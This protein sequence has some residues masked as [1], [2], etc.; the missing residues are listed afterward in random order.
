MTKQRPEQH[1]GPPSVAKSNSDYQ[2]T[3]GFTSTKERWVELAS[4]ELVGGHHELHVSSSWTP[5]RPT[6]T[7]C[8]Q[9]KC[10]GSRKPILPLE[11]TKTRAKASVHK[12]IENHQEHSKL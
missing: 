9:D 8:N 6:F 12:G 10:L 5:H 7:A 1:H 2:R 11:P 4:A 3:A